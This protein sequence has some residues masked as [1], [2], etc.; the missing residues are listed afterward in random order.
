MNS[1]P[2]EM[3]W[4]KFGW[5]LQKLV[6]LDKKS[7]KPHTRILH[8]TMYTVLSPLENYWNEPSVYREVVGVFSLCRYYSDTVK[9][10]LTTSL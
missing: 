10:T 1:R 4:D 2:T 9:F 5:K 6:V 8:V 7:F 3:P